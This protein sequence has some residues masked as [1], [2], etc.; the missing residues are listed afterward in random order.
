MRNTITKVYI[1]AA[2]NTGGQS[3]SKGNQ[4]ESVYSMAIFYS[5]KEENKGVQ[6]KERFLSR[7]GG[8]RAY[9][10]ALENFIKSTVSGESYNVYVNF[11]PIVMEWNNRIMHKSAVR[12]AGNEDIW[13]SITKEINTRRITLDV[14]YERYL[15]NERHYEAKKLLLQQLKIRKGELN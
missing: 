1:G 12:R 4:T 3:N 8:Y 5:G 7:C 14:K 6:I 15:T 11:K 13:R 9:L 10:I 2:S